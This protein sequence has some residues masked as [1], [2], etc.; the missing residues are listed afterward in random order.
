MSALRE[1]Q[2]QFWRLVTAPEPV[3]KVLPELAGRHPE[4]SP[5]TRWVRAADEETAAQRLNVY[6]LAGF[7]LASSRNGC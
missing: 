1:L 5:L 3:D 4:I 2:E 7:P 6:A